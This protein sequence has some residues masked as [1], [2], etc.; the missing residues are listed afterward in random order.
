M[1]YNRKSHELAAFQ[2]LHRRIRINSPAREC[3]NCKGE[4]CDYPR[5][6]FALGQIA[7]SLGRRSLIDFS[8]LYQDRLQNT[9]LCRSLICAPI[10]YQEGCGFDIAVDT[11]VNTLVQRSVEVGGRR[12]GLGVVRVFG[13]SGG[14]AFF[15]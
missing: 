8:L 7:A 4:R 9:R 11:I 6:R 15:P 13:G 14:A 2:A 3:M 5:K 10:S 12:K 1:A